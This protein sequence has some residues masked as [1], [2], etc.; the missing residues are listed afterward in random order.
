MG[1]SSQPKIFRCRSPAFRMGEQTMIEA[2][3]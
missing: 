1:K 2:N 3:K